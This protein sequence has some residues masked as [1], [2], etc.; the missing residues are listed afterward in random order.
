MHT[1]QNAVCACV[2]FIVTMHMLCTTNEQEKQVERKIIKIPIA[3]MNVVLTYS[4]CHV[5]WA[6]VGAYERTPKEGEGKHRTE[7]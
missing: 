4:S 1:Q 7:T 2:Y 3:E 5:H 6:S